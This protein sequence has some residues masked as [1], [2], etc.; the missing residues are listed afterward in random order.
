MIHVETQ[1]LSHALHHVDAVAARWGRML[2]DARWI[3][4]QQSV[5]M[6]PRTQRFSDP[7][8]FPVTFCLKGDGARL[9]VVLDERQWPVMGLLKQIS[10]H[11]RKE[12]VVNLWTRQVLTQLRD[13][14]C[15]VEHCIWTD[16][17]QL[18][19]AARVSLQFGDYALNL[20]P[21]NA[22]ARFLD[23]LQTFLTTLA[24]PMRLRLAQ[25]PL[26]TLVTL[27]ERSFSLSRLGTLK[28]GDMVFW[29]RSSCEAI[30][31]QG[32]V[33][34]CSSGLVAACQTRTGELT[35]KEAL[36]QESHSVALEEDNTETLHTAYASLQLKIRFEIDGPELTVA[37]A[38][39]LVPGEVIALPIP[40]DQAH[41]RLRCQGRCFAH[42]E[43]VNVGGQ[44]GV[45]IL[46]VGG[47]DVQSQ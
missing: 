35:M 25:W 46:E 11:P 4:L 14:G 21:E 44:L 29:G 19:P 9:L 45:R 18:P 40:V 8:D 30:R 34:R 22:S 3:N 26:A 36:H 6:L 31:I 24:V 39:S 47:L 32:S 1:P 27:G 23:G 2:N 17:A 5:E 10:D 12:A 7:L 13:V 37:Q 16:D 43:L 41:V 20:Y 38:A 15:Q 42:G 33:S 28:V